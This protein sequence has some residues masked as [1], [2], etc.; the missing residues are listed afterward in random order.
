MLASGISKGPGTHGVNIAQGIRRRNL[1]ECVGVINDR[2]EEIDRL[3]QRYIRCD[4]IH[5]RVVGVIEADKHV[6]VMLPG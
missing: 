1:S 3:H 4:T 5:A 6:L 2:S